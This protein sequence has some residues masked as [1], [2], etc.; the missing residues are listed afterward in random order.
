MADRFMQQ[1]AGPARSEHHRHGACRSRPRIEIYDSVSGALLDRREEKD[2]NEGVHLIY[3][4][5]RQ[6][7]VKIIPSA[8][9]DLTE[10]YGLFFDPVTIQPVRIDPGGG[11]F[12]GKVEVTA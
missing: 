3:V 12:N 11:V 9:M 1:Y 10:I 4:V 8:W 7:H 6:V 2:L 5:S